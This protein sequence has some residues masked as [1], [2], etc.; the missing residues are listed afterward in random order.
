[1]RRSYSIA[2]LLGLSCLLGFSSGARA[3]VTI[4]VVFQDATSPS[5]ITIN[6]GDPGPGCSFSGYYG[7][8]A[9]T[10]YC[11]DVIMTT[12]ESLGIGGSMSVSVTY[13]SDDGLV[14][15]SMREWAG[16]SMLIKGWGGQICAPAGGLVDNGGVLQSFDCIA[17]SPPQL[18][19]FAAGTYQIGTIIW[20]TSATTPGQEV[21]QA[22]LAS[23]DGVTAVINGNVVDISASVVLGSHILTIVPE[24][25]TAT[26]LG[27]GFVGLVLAVRRR[28]PLQH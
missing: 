1:M 6:A 9:T 11:M 26:L 24:P 17:P 3:G 16:L 5:G 12:T 22:L 27:L 20:D 15:E 2:L 28:R 25:G 21:I 4:D 19:P 14:V 13:D 8:S 7:G 23:G 18:F 10:G